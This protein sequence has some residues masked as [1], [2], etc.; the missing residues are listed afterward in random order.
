L[1]TVHL[2]ELHARV[3]EFAMAVQSVVVAL[4]VLPQAVV[5]LAVHAVYP[6][7]G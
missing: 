5:E 1:L 3:T 4:V 6:E 2:P 7:L